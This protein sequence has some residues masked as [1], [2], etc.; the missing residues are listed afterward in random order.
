MSSEHLPLPLDLLI[1]RLEAAGFRV[2]TSRR[3][4]MLRVFDDL[5]NPFVGGHFEELKY[6]LSPLVSRSPQEQERFYEIFDAFWRECEAEAVQAEA[7]GVF[8]E[9]E[10][11]AGVRAV[12]VKPKKR[13]WVWWV[14]GAAV[15]LVA[16]EAMLYS[17]SIVFSFPLTS[18]RIQLAEGD[19][20]R[21]PAPE[22]TEFEWGGVDISAYAKTM[23]CWEVRDFN[24][25][26][27][28]HRDTQ[29]LNWPVGL[30]HGRDLFV[31]KHTTVSALFYSAVEQDSFNLSIE[32]S[33][34]PEV[35]EITCTQKPD[36]YQPNTEYEFSIKTE[37]GCLVTWEKDLVKGDT[38]P[39][40][41]K[42]YSS[43][44]MKTYG[45]GSFIYLYATVHRPEKIGYCYTQSALNISV[46]NNKPILQL[47][48]FQ[49]DE[50][51]TVF[52][53]SRLG[54]LLIALPLLLAGW[55]FRRW[56][57]KR[58]ASAPQKT[59]EELAAQYPVTDAGPYFIPYLPQ[60]HNITVPREFF[61]IAELLRRR[62]EG[63][64]RYFDGPATVRATID[65]GGFPAWR[66]RAV[67]RPAEYLF[68]VERPDEREQ[69]GHLFTRLCDFLKRREVPM[70]AFFHDGSFGHFWN[71][72]APK[73]LP[74]AELRRRY[75][76]HRLVLLGAAHGL[77]NPYASRQPEL[78]REPLDGL[79][80]WPRRLL[81]TPEPV[82]A[83]SFQEALL[84]RHFLLFPADTEGILSGIDLL[85]RTEE[86]HS[87]RFERWQEG[88]APRHSPETHRYR[89]WK[90]ATE[91]ADYL[92][93]DPECYRWLRALAVCP[94]PD[95]SLTLA[96][97]RAVGAEVTHDRLLRLTRIPWL[98]QNQPNDG[99]RLDLLRQLSPA[100]EQAARTAVARELEAV[101]HLTANSF[102]D[103]ERTANAAVQ[104]FA[105]DPRD[106][107]YK[108]A[109]RDLRALGLVSGS[110]EAELDFIVQEKADKQGLPDAAGAGIASWLD[111][112]APKRFWTR[113]MVLG[114]LSV[115]LSFFLTVGLLVQASQQKNFSAPFDFLLENVAQDNE[116]IQLNEQAIGI[117]ERVLG[118]EEWERW[119]DV[120]RIGI[121]VQPEDMPIEARQGLLDSL[122]LAESLFE[123]VANMRLVS[124]SAGLAN[125][126][127]EN[128]LGINLPIFRY[129]V[130]AKIFNFHQTEDL[131][132]E[133]LQM[134]VDVFQTAAS[135]AR[136]LP[137]SNDEA[138]IKR[139]RKLVADAEHGQGLCHYYLS[140]YL[141][142]QTLPTRSGKSPAVLD[143]IVQAQKTQ[144]D[145][146]RLVYQRLSESTAY[147]NYFA[148]I[149]EA[150]PVN[151]ETLLQADKVLDTDKNDDANTDEEIKKNLAGYWFYERA[152]SVKVINI[153]RKDGSA[154]ML[155]Y[156]PENKPE[157]TGTGKWSV[158]NKNLVLV[159]DGDVTKSEITYL[160]NKRLVLDDG[161]TLVLTFR[162][163]QPND[164]DG[165]GV[166]DVVDNCPDEKGSKLG[167][168]RP[169]PPYCSDDAGCP[170][171]KSAETASDTLTI[172]AVSAE[173]GNG[174]L[175]VTFKIVES[176]GKDV[177]EATNYSENQMSFKVKGSKYLAIASKEGFLPDT[178]SVNTA[179]QRF[180]T[181]RLQPKLIGPAYMPPV[182]YFDSGQPDPQS[183]AT[184][185][186][187]QYSQLY[188]AYYSRKEEYIQRYV[189]GLSKE[190]IAAATDS[191]DTFFEDDVRG[192]W[193]MMRFLLESLYERLNSGE[194][195]EL[196]LRGYTSPQNTATYNLNLSRRRIGSVINEFL[197][198]D[199]G[200]LKRFTENGQL[201]FRQEPYGESKAPASMS[202]NEKDPR[203]SVYSPEAVRQSRVEIIEVKSNK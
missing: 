164:R 129:N 130:A 159:Q 103:T 180:V 24:T 69:Q 141:A 25:R 68:L 79:L 45:P 114:I 86:Y 126:G 74:P 49:R 189:S 200:A 85:D 194:K 83:W 145:S 73:G 18:F 151:L 155:V 185:T 60:E 181:L 94:Q 62:E 179:S 9:G 128:R 43:F 176:G 34:P 178:V 133:G 90:T 16:A 65:S 160:D 195:I 184:T 143:S 203:R 19:T 29:D 40:D 13:W 72:D 75:P 152:G 124:V 113:D 110:Q 154:S 30:G 140:K 84:H 192:G 42:G 50:T 96:I 10:K 121:S 147:P 5:G 71:A 12:L 53:I 105:L 6:L 134:P 198:F 101:R 173:N 106:E 127:W 67:T 3:L 137:E 57:K 78:L 202:D 139:Q 150:M 81:L 52:T 177:Q 175:E 95:W 92:R 161:T 47:A 108:Q 187:Q 120:A 32:C 119:K 35:S 199:G 89:T 100:D 135:A 157:Q 33:N 56:W 144:L 109:I 131:A 118:V 166:L 11:T 17:A 142:S 15:L 197:V 148:E 41:K 51:F 104:N 26:E 188:F 23:A 48:E 54:W 136:E 191:L 14:L 102:A 1:G 93:D 98:S 172:A 99:L 168:A 2:D 138:L 190:Q 77:V 28:L 162:R 8:A 115:F 201:T 91:H 186:A 153:F 158:E 58:N 36:F 183:M 44:R 88:R 76:H 20:L 170:E 21:H 116:L 46:G 182:L 38:F 66:E 64:R 111:V 70:A 37:P 39:T 165:D 122:N 7:S 156:T 169:C 193:G 149:Q 132:G 63:H 27:L 22:G 55:F 125:Y 59:P 80:H 87:G 97:G 31:A 196:I 123:K 163:I 107:T 61:R 112:P 174:L 82:A 117:A 167:F 4:R 171:G 146:A